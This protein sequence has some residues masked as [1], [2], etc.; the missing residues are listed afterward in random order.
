M[1]DPAKWS[2]KK[3]KPNGG[4]ST[5][6]IYISITFNQHKMITAQ[7]EHPIKDYTASDITS[8][9]KEGTTRDVFCFFRE[10]ETVGLGT[11]S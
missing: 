6:N 11:T 2:G 1:V 4:Q 8:N 10:A 9:A 7:T 5:A 3:E